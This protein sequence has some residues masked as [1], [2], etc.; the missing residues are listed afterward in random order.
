MAGPHKKKMQK[1]QLVWDHIAKMPQG[2]REDDPIGLTSLI[3]SIQN[4]T[5]NN[6]V[7]CQQYAE[8]LTATGSVHLKQ[9]NKD[10]QAWVITPSK[11][12]SEEAGDAG[13]DYLSAQDTRD[14]ADGLMD[15]AAPA[16][17]VK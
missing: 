10:Y 6:K 1:I 14:S 2:L 17:M 11:P 3:R 5:K 13:K 4:V 16:E 15:R 8:I 12:P 7:T 9:V